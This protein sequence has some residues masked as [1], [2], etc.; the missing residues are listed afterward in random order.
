[1]LQPPHPR[2]ERGDGCGSPFMRVRFRTFVSSWSSWDELFGQAAAF[3]TELGPQRLINI[4]HSCDQK[5]GVVSVWYWD[6][7]EE[8]VPEEKPQD[9]T[10]EGD[11]PAGWDAG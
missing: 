1:M 2:G 4:S 8:A 10:Q 5:Q 11:Q 9:A 6:E 3:A 7:D